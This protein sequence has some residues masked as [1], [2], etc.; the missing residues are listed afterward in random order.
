MYTKQLDTFLAVAR[1]GSFSKAARILYVTPSAI[2]QQI[3]S[4]EE[5]LSATLFY[6]TRQGVTL[7]PAGAV[8]V[9][10]A[11]KLIAQNRTL[12]Q[13]VADAQSP[14]QS[15][16]VGTGI[17]QKCRLFHQ[18]W[19]PFAQQHAACSFHMVNMDMYKLFDD[20]RVE[21]FESIA[22]DRRQP[23]D[24][25]FLR[26]CDMP[27]VCAV[28]P[29]HPLARCTR[30]TLDAL[31]GTP[32]VTIQSGLACAT[33][34]LNRDCKAR[35]IPL[36]EVSSYDLSVFSACVG[37]QH[38]M[39]TPL[40]W[41]DIHPEFTLI[42]CAWPYALQ[43]GFYYRKQCGQTAQTFIRFAAQGRATLDAQGVFTFTAR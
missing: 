2:I 38:P 8:L 14:R 20:S 33:D 40:C 1:T 22:Y 27:I 37:E 16:C 29:G 6:R 12:R 13:R 42:P 9:E 31:E 43:Y 5:Q 19:K 3:N 26:M 7:T 23:P 39:Q 18:I 21:L 32:L 30:L 25:A 24:W 10:E 36:I 17:L 41:R 34:Q 4:L 15:L 11:E 28:P 35:G